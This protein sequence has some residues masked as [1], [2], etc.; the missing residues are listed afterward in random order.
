MKFSQE[1]YEKLI[2]LVRQRPALYNCQLRQYKD[3]QL[4]RNMWRTIAHEMGETELTGGFI[5]FL[6]N[7][8][9]YQIKALET[10]K[11]FLNNHETNAVIEVQKYQ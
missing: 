11:Y 4:H 10:S 5:Y 2:E 9:H 7:T 3:Q 6:K 8:F 1:K